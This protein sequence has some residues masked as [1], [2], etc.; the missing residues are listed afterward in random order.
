V[1]NIAAACH[2]CNQ[3][4]HRRKAAPNPKK[5]RRYVLRLVGRGKWHDRCV[6]DAGLLT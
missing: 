5:F 2:R 4:R 3:G 6:H 1:A